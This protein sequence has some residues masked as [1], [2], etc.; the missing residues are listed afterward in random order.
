MKTSKPA[1]LSIL[2]GILVI[3]G[4]LSF[5][6]Q[7]K[8][9]QSGHEQTAGLVG[10]PTAKTK[11]VKPTNPPKTATPK[12][13]NTATRSSGI[14]TTT[15]S[16]SAS[17]PTGSGVPGTPTSTPTA[18]STA[19]ARQTQ[20]AQSVFQTSTSLARSYSP[21]PTNFGAATFTP[22]VWELTV[23]SAAL[24]A[25]PTGRYLSAAAVSTKATTPVSIPVSSSGEAA[26]SQPSKK[27]SLL[28]PAILLVFIVLCFLLYRELKKSR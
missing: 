26:V 22:Q 7:A 15:S 11:R 2:L 12:P 28:I 8:S 18:V 6:V 13:A 23:T 9:D 19:A 24:T 27:M 1:S 10:K 4:L 14:S 3:L 20:T 21:T 16:T 17:Q 25:A 5:P